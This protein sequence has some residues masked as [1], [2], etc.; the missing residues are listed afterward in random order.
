MNSDK[1][2]DLNQEIDHDALNVALRERSGKV[3]LRT[4]IASFL[5]ELM[6]D[7]V[8]PGTVE[9]IARQSQEYP[10]LTCNGFLAK[11]AI[12]VATRLYTPTDDDQFWDK[13]REELR[14]CWKRCEQPLTDAQVENLVYATK[15]YL[16]SSTLNSL[17]RSSIAQVRDWLRRDENGVE[18][19]ITLGGQAVTNL[20]GGPRLFEWC[21]RW[22]HTSGEGL[23][24]VYGEKEAL[25]FASRL[26]GLRPEDRLN[27]CRASDEKLDLLELTSPHGDCRVTVFGDT[28][29]VDALAT[30]AGQKR[31]AA[32]Y[33]R[34]GDLP[35]TRR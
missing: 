32:S 19:G 2:I 3:K 12:D 18:C 30:V 15:F 13:V 31:Y 22:P 23:H 6:R 27:P 5:Y 14:L 26:I 8:V 29:S 35:Y 24:I 11:Y 9:K 21:F 20:G 7:E 17:R 10:V 16:R 4:R 28:P 1:T 25:R 34:S 33:L